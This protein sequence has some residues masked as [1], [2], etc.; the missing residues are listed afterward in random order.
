MIKEFAVEPGLAATWGRADRS[1]LVYE[2]FVNSPARLIGEVPQGWLALVDSLAEKN[3]LDGLRLECLL[4][5]FKAQ[6]RVR[7]R[8]G[9]FWD[10]KVTWLENARRENARAPFAA[11]ICGRGSGHPEVLDGG[12]LDSLVK[13]PRWR[14]TQQV[15]VRKTKEALARA[16]RDE[17]A[18]SRI[19]YFVDPYFHPGNQRYREVFERLL[20]L[21]ASRAQG[22][23]TP[24]A[25]IVRSSHAD[26]ASEEDFASF[27]KHCGGQGGGLSIRFWEVRPKKGHKPLHD[28][29]LVTELAG[30]VLSSGFDESKGATTVQLALMSHETLKET[31]RLL[32]WFASPAYYVEE[33]K[34]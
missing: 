26:K 27:R 1:A 11:V 12:D 5:Q 34:A 6:K 9:L 23:G 2:S 20:P 33:L 17:L 16:L 8:V 19:V 24:I 14:I 10:P 13:D 7:S 4:E 21:I 28:R 31:R 32:D 25:T 30:I 18:L 22:Q 15:Q 3:G 29:F